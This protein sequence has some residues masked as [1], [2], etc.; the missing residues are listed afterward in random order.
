[1]CRGVR[2][3]TKLL[4]RCPSWMGQACICWELCWGHCFDKRHDHF[5][6]KPLCKVWSFGAFMHASSVYFLTQPFDVVFIVTSCRAIVDLPWVTEFTWVTSCKQHYHCVKTLFPVDTSTMS[7]RTQDNPDATQFTHQM[8]IPEFL[9]S[10]MQ[11]PTELLKYG[12][13][14]WHSWPQG[15]PTGLTR[16]TASLPCG[17]LPTG[18][19]SRGPWSVHA[20][21]QYSTHALGDASWYCSFQHHRDSRVHADII[22]WRHMGWRTTRG[23]NHPWI[24]ELAH[25]NPGVGYSFKYWSTMKG[26]FLEVIIVFL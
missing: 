25:K 8:K 2:G 5:T 21:Q 11:V 14:L 23:V 22:N 7:V 4:W 13:Q 16:Y 19:E 24:V 26:Q 1:M 3:A 9:C 20:T 18:P 6:G 17:T 12:S 15:P 10:K